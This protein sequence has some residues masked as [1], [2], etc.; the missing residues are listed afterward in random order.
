MKR[1]LTIL[2]VVAV[3]FFCG[4]NS[5][6]QSQPHPENQSPEWLNY[7]N[8]DTVMDIVDNGKY[9]WIGTINGGIVRL[10]KVT[11]EL[12][13]YNRANAG[14]PANDIDSLATDSDG[15]LWIGSVRSGIGMFDGKNCTVYNEE[16]SDFPYDGWTTEIETD[17]DGNKWIGS[18]GYLSK[19]DGTGWTSA[20]IGPALLPH[21]DI[22]DIEFDR[23]G[24]VWIGTSLG[25]G[26]FDE[27]ELQVDYVVYEVY[28]EVSA[29]EIDSDDNI[30]VG[31]GEGLIK[32]DGENMTVFDTDN[33]Q[34]PDNTITSLALDS[35][36]NVWLGTSH[37]GLVKFDG[38]DWEV[39]NTEN[40]GLPENNIYAVETDADG[41]I[42]CGLSQSGLVKY[43]GDSWKKYQTTNSIFP[44]DFSVNDIETDSRQNIWI[45]TYDGLMK[46]DGED[47]VIYDSANSGLIYTSVRSLE[48][49]SNNNIWMSA[50]KPGTGNEHVLVKYDGEN[51][52]TIDSPLP[53]DQYWG[54][55]A[56]SQGIFWFTSGEG[57]FRFDGKNWTNYNTDNSPIISNNISSVAFDPE[58][59]VWIGLYPRSNDDWSSA[60]LMMFDREGKWITYNT[61]NSEIPYD[62]V[63]GLAVDSDGIV[64]LGTL[65]NFG[66][67]YSRYGGGLTKFDGKKWTSYTEDNSEI[68]NNEIWGICI[69]DADNLWLGGTDKGLVKYD[70][71]NEWTVYD[72]SN[73]GIVSNGVTVIAVDSRHNIW[74]GHNWMSGLSVFREGGVTFRQESP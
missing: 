69:D 4:C 23:E 42:W 44:Y 25:F 22:N 38:T 73:S 50:S 61:N 45:G 55:K 72:Q 16:N 8:G 62:I 18:G 24:N 67:Q 9:L 10:N 71:E 39:F 13:F 19:F 31:T 32:Y 29:L 52:T 40:S 60:G 49:D 7:T 48:S 63:T 33:S 14:I 37:E 51:W 12:T 53:T 65:S 59:N 41:N 74:T 20:D 56:D 21:F 26:R 30:W 46:F 54:I 43:D 28:M 5:S 34:L 2:S 3:L 27:D 1:H 17:P 47:W 35:E 70:R 66:F 58:G 64:W 6:T 68:P 57:L 36:E 15:N 11:D